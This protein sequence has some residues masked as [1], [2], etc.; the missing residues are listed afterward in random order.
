MGM[1]DGTVPGAGFGAGAD[2]CG[3]VGS[4]GFAVLVVGAP[5]LWR[6]SLSRIVVKI[7]M[8]YPFFD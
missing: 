1:C 8:G 7:L 5:G 2:V 3:L 4:K 6:P